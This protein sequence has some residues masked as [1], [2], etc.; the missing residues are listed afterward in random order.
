LDRRRDGGNG[1]PHRAG[2]KD[3]AH[4]NGTLLLEGGQ[5]RRTPYGYGGRHVSGLRQ[6]CGALD[7]DDGRGGQMTT[8]AIVPSVHPR[9][10]WRSTGAVLLGFVAVVVLSLGTDQVLHWL[11]VY[12]PWN[13]GMHEPG[14]NLLALAYRTAYAILGSYITA[15]F[16]PHS[17][18]YHAMVGG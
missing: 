1:A 2:F 12:P 5:R 10:I 14:L 9:R 8:Q 7:L 6:A 18:M 16:A 17:P 3:D 11:K 4:H 15:R 13:E